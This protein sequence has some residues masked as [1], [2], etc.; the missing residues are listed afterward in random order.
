MEIC[1]GT[2]FLLMKC[3]D[4]IDFNLL[5][6]SLKQD[7]FMVVSIDS[8]IAGIGEIKGSRVSYITEVQSNY[9]G[10]LYEAKREPNSVFFDK[11]LKILFPYLKEIKKILVS[12]PG[13]LKLVFKNYIESSN[14]DKKLQV[15]V[16]EGVDVAGFDGIRM[17]LNSENFSKVLRDNFFSK[18]RSALANVLESLYKGDGLASAS[19]EEIEYMSI[20]GA[21]DS[22]L[23]SKDYLSKSPADEKKIVQ[24]FSNLT[25]Y[26]G[27]LYLMDDNTNVGIQ[28]GTLGG[29]VALFRYRIK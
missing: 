12:G 23:V 20:N 13:S 11:I 19:L 15:V 2:K 17:A 6:A 28:L 8:M 16:L 18:A 25:K 22:L 4:E 3:D 27:S 26:K 5:R 29:I 21:C 24:I 7:Q 14:P 9:Q 1:P 10:K